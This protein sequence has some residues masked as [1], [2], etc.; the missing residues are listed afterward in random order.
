ML[1]RF[2]ALTSLA[3]GTAIVVAAAVATPALAK[4][5]TQAS[6]TGP[7][8][9]RPVTISA[10]GE[11]L[12]GQSDALSGLADQT[13]LFTVLFGPGNGTPDGPSALRTPPAAAS[14]GP[15]YTLTYTVPGVTP[16]PGQP[17]GQIRQYLYPRAA[18]G[19]VIYTLPGQQGFG[20]PLQA[21]GWL[22]G[23]PQLT[24]TLTRLG[25]PAG[26]SVS[27]APAAAASVSATP[28]A[29]PK[30]GD[31]TAPAWL[32]A[33]IVSAVVIA[34]AGTAW[35]LR[36]RVRPVNDRSATG[37][38]AAGEASGQPPRAPAV[39]SERNVLAV[40]AGRADGGADARQGRR[41]VALGVGHHDLRERV[42]AIQAGHDGLPCLIQTDHGVLAAK[43]AAARPGAVLHEGQVPGRPRFA[44]DPVDAGDRRADVGR[45]QVNQR[46]LGR[47]DLAHDPG[48]YLFR[49]ARGRA[50]DEGRHHRVLQEAPFQDDHRPSA[51]A[52]LGQPA[53]L[54]VR[55][56]AAAACS[57]GVRGAARR[58]GRLQAGFRP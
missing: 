25:V 42:A 44:A 31:M 23:T 8:L 41:P 32:I 46:R 19:P 6:I 58:P 3:A 45:A 12:P 14:L 55:V 10:Q 33:A 51:Q 28:A 43:A 48:E 4:G 18:G 29:A 24:A 7:G 35:W 9:T 39:R 15:R 56:R 16:G 26:A 47:P 50:V 30:P 40:P 1:R 52:A 36:R 13:G 21:A 54:I 38:P 2:I 49:P 11:A 57:P 34:V 5:A 20:Q 27:S 53:P 22:R 17:D 37:Q